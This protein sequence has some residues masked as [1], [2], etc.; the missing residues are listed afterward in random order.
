MTAELDPLCSFIACNKFGMGMFDTYVDTIF[1]WIMHLQQRE[2]FAFIV[3]VIRKR[4]EHDRSAYLTGINYKMNG[5]IVC[6]SILFTRED[7]DGNRVLT[8][9]DCEFFE[10]LLNLL[11]IGLLIVV[12][13]LCVLRLAY[14]IFFFVL[15]ILFIIY[16]RC[17][18]WDLLNIWELVKI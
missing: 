5:I 16:I 4:N 11:V 8:Y 1:C 3:T 9:N 17:L 7:W 2:F 6:C 14:K 15:Q 18:I 10:R 13:W 12:N